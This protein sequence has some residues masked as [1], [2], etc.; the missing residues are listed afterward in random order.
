VEINAIRRFIAVSGRDEDE[1]PDRFRA[2]G[3]GA[4]L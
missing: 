3:A 1:V 4:V 2:F